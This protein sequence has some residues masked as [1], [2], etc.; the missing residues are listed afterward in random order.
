MKKIQPVTDLSIT[1]E[2][3]KNLVS[4]ALNKFREKQSDSVLKQVGFLLERIDLMQKIID[5]SQRR[6]DLCQGQ[7]KAINDGK[8]KVRVDGISG[9]P[10][11]VFEDEDLNVSWDAT[12][13]W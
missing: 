11:F 12:E 13:R 8:F 4:Q 5:K 2:Q 7:M 10:Y 1:S 9:D 6:L 3:G